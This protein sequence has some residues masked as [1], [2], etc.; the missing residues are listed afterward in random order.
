MLD[1]VFNGTP[2]QKGLWLPL[3]EAIC[4]TVACHKSEGAGLWVGL[5][6]GVG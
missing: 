4:I 2:K 6:G 5:G 3:E 1:G